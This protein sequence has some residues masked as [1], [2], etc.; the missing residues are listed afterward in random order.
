MTDLDRKIAEL[1][2]WTSEKDQGP[3]GQDYQAK[4]YHSR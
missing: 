3:E 1:K 4:T 2:G